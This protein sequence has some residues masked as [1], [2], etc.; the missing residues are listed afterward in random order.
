MELTQK[1]QQGVEIAVKRYKE[2]KKFTIISGYAGT[3]KSTTVRY[4]VKALGVPENKI[5]YAT[6]TGKAAQVLSQ[7]G[8]KN[9]MTLHRL[10]FE[11]KLLPDG[12]FLR[13]PKTSIE[14][15]IV[16]VDEISMAPKSLIDSLIYKYPNVYM[17]GLGDPGQLPPISD[18][19]NNHLLDNPHIFL[20][21]IMRQAEDSE[22]IKVSMDIRQGKTLSCFDGNQVKIINK[23]DLNTGMLEWADQILCATNNTRHSINMQMRQ[24]KGIEGKYPTIGDKVI[25][26]KNYWDIANEKDDAL[27]NG[28]IGYLDGN[29]SVHTTVF[30]HWLKLENSR[31]EKFYS[32]LKTEFGNFNFLDLD[33]EMFVTGKPTLDNKEEYKV[34]KSKYR[35]SIPLRFEYG[36]A[37]TVWKAQGSQFNNVLVFEENFPFD[38]EEHKKYLYT[39]IT[40]AID[41]CIIVKNN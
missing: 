1:Q 7:K 17:I 3:G 32:N 28:T 18:N 29:I 14:Y 31:V 2:G 16:I 37:I 8:N 20:D 19:E 35:N 39:A 33:K 40:R 26:T 34:Y 12:S 6:F 27:V 9:S 24:L 13:T 5:C 41:K 23:Q 30:P 11:S 21:E 4:I 36:Y 10:L 25:C 22:I 15:D 38:K